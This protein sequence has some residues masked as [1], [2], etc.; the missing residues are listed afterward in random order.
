MRSFVRFLASLCLAATAVAQQSDACALKPPKGASTALIVYEDLECPVCSVAYPQV[1]D[2][3]KTYKIPAILR[4]F[5]L[6]Q[7]HWSRQ[8]SI[9]ARY[10]D[11]LGAAPKSKNRNLGNDFRA[12]IYQNQPAITADNLVDYASKF[13]RQHGAELPFSVDPDGALE[14]KVN[15]D[16]DCGQRSGINHT[17]TIYIVSSDPK[18][19]RVEVETRDLSRLYEKIEAVL[20]RASA[21]KK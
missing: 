11:Q 10:F 20:P 1:I 5:P 17:P 19:P 6:P 14:K 16:R 4:D 21:S 13:A 2:A 18:K 15:A 8:A 3:A 12:Y 7:H 9:M